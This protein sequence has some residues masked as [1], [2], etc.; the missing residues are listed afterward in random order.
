MQ[1]KEQKIPDKLSIEFNL[2]WP[3]SSHNNQHS[4]ISLLLN[5]LS[6]HCAQLLLLKMTLIVSQGV[7]SSK[8]GIKE[9]RLDRE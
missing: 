1:H 8:L 7:K 4:I 3:G 5:A 9:S 2:Q 6:S